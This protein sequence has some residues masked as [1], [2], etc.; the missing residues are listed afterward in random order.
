MWAVRLQVSRCDACG[1][2]ARLCPSDAIRIVD[3]PQEGGASVALRLSMGECIGCGVCVDVCSPAALT[4][5]VP[6]TETVTQRW[7]NMSNVNCERCGKTYR[8][9]QGQPSAVAGLCPGCR[10]GVMPR[11]NRLVQAAED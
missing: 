1:A 6:L 2:C 10:Q 11:R 9:L 3:R 7:L 4:Q 5:A 8:V